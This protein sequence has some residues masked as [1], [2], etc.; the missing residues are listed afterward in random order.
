MGKLIFDKTTNTDIEQAP[1]RALIEVDD[2][3]NLQVI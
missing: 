2:S 1:I 3:K